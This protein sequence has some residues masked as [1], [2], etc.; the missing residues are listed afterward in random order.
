VKGIGYSALT[1]VSFGALISFFPIYFEHLFGTSYAKN[2]VIS[3]ILLILVT[4]PLTFFGRLADKYSYKKILIYCT[5][6]IILLILTLRYLKVDSYYS[7]GIVVMLAVLFSCLYAILP[8]ILTDLFP[9]SLR[10]TGTALTFNIADSFEGLTPVA[11]F[12]ILHVSGSQNTYFWVLII[13]ALISLGTY[14]TIKVKPVAH[15]E[16]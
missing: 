11:A 5:S 14:L 15:A 7:F 1:A 8:F 12:Y 9:A 10:F 16:G 2:L 4:F 3:I 6:L 13:C